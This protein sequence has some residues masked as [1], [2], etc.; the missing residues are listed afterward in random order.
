MM[1]IDAAVS[2]YDVFEEIEILK[3]VTA[4]ELTEYLSVLT[5][6]KAVMSVILP[7]ER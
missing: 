5:E 6:D 7:K 2:E 1:F 3:S 4:D